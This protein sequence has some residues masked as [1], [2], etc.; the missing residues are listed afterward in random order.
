MMEETMKRVDETVEGLAAGDKGPKGKIK[1]LT[2]RSQRLNAEYE[3]IKYKDD[4]NILPWQ[5]QLKVNRFM[6]ELQVRTHI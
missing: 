3:K 6:A 1:A 4:V 5:R 2:P